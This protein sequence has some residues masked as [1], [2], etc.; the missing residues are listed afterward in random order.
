[1]VLLAVQWWMLTGI[2]DGKFDTMASESFAKTSRE[3]MFNN[4]QIFFYIGMFLII[5]L[6]MKPFIND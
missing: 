1:M 4:I 2:L 6:R 3:A 5:A